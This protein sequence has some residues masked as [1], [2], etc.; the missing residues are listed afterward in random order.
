MNAPAVI[1]EPNRESNGRSHMAPDLLG[2]SSQLPLVTHY[3]RVALRWKWVIL[4]IIAATLVLGIVVTAIMTRQY[5][6]ITTVEISRA[7]DKVVKIEG[8]EQESNSADLEFYQTQYG[9]LMSRELAEQVAIELNLV[10][11][12][13]FFAA[14]GKALSDDAT[15]SAKKLTKSVV[16]KPRR[17]RA[18]GEILIKHVEIIPVRLSRLVLISF[19]APD[20][21]LAAKVAN[22]WSSNFI[23]ANLQRRF[24]ATSYARAFLENRLEQLRGKL[25]QSERALVAYASR[26]RIIN[27]PSSNG[28]GGD[29]SLEADDLAALNIELNAATADRIRAESRWRQ[30]GSVGGGAAPEAL[31]NIAING[32]RQ[33]RGEVAADYAKQLTQFEPEYPAARALASELARLDQSIAREESRVRDSIGRGY[34]EA[35]GREVALRGRLN[36]LQHDYIDLK[37]R[38]IQ[39]NIFQRDADTNRQL[40]DGLLQRYK[41]IGIAGGVGTNNVSIVDPAVVP[42]RPSRPNLLLNLALALLCGVALGAIAA[43]ILEQVDE[44]ITSPAEVERLLNL[45]LL[46][47]IPKAHGDPIENLVD[48]KSGIVEAYLSV[49]TNLEFSTEHGVPRS[50]GVTSTRPS[51][52]KSTTA[53]AL[54]AQLVRARKRV[55]LIDGDM[56]S[57]SVHTMLGLANNMGLS[58][59]L[60]GN[61]DLAP[62]IQRD[63][64]FGLS[65]LCAG[66]TP[67][68][69]AELLTGDRLK[70]LIERLGKT[71]DHILIDSPPVMGLA[72]GPLIASRVEGMIFVVE[73][74]GIRSS[75]VRVALGRLM[76]A[77]SRAVGAV[78][79][80]FDAERA[81]FGYGYDYG[82]GYGHSAADE[83]SPAS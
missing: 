3:L 53:M 32:L 62:M 67:P 54:A 4:G 12:P 10:D 11:N 37:R 16:D 9:L 6:A 36:G 65:V 60:A 49:Q 80:K 38:S 19:T 68:N 73:S 33:K 42:E 2:T 23:K 57:P 7:T 35:R 25:D 5:T 13:D 63:E 55:V 46:G 28:G 14:F 20:P 78:L 66:P 24:D 1:N 40:Y 82:Y 81:H 47:A 45:P 43:L 52:G 34:R 69:A 31:T 39:Y 58:N 72:D 74:H 64:R 44:A 77:N 8:V 41:E 15:P 26:E 76:N 17:Q 21:V 56:R 30:S 75:M 27:V 29:R 59:F 18:A 70:M 22:A 51:E 83:P 61:D 50:L 71:F 48:R 79:T